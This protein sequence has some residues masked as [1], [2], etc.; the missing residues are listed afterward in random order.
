MV[1]AIQPGLLW[2]RRRR[3]FVRCGILCVSDWFYCC[4]VALNRLVGWPR[5]LVGCCV[6]PRDAGIRWD[7]TQ[8][9]EISCCVIVTLWEILDQWNI[10]LFKSPRKCIKL[11]LISPLIL[12]PSVHPSLSSAVITFQSQTS[13]QRFSVY[14]LSPWRLPSVSLLLRIVSP[15]LS[16]PSLVIS[17]TSVL[18]KFSFN[19]QF[20]PYA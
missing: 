16:K 17:E 10:F 4:V 15:I 20:S 12:W 11:G 19:H 2:R 3:D 8:G 18:S 6:F 1:T 5:F 9:C 14:I 7:N 13:H